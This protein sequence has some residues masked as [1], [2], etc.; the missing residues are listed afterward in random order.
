MQGPWHNQLFLQQGLTLFSQSIELSALLSD[1]IG[2][3]FLGLATG[4]TCGLFHQLPEIAL[5]NCDTIVELGSG[6]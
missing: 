1:A 5:K 2:V 3:T 6:K 4:A